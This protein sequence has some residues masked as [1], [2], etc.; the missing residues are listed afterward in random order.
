MRG[1][2]AGFHL[3]QGELWSGRAA[4]LASVA[5]Q[6]AVT[7]A[8][9]ADK[10]VS[11]RAAGATGRRRVVGQLAELVIW[12]IVLVL[13]VREV[14]HKRRARACSASHFSH[15]CMQMSSLVVNALRA[16]PSG[17]NI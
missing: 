16:L 15:S 6:G 12:R 13:V 5:E 1:C 7:G 11:R 4:C 8:L 9:L 10:L 17:R 3:S 2:A 14:L